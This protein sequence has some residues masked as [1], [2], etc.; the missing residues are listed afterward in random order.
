MNKHLLLQLATF[1]S[2][3]S[4]IILTAAP[5]QA[6]SMGYSTARYEGK[7]SGC[8][9]G[10]FLDPRNGGECWSC[11]NDYNRTLYAVTDDKACAKP[12]Y[13]KLK[14]AHKVRKNSRIGQG[15]GRGDFWDMK[16]GDGLLGACY[17]CSGWD[18]TAYAVDSKRACS[19][20]YPEKFAKA[21]KHGRFGCGQGQ[22]FDPR[23]YGE[24]WSCPDAYKFRTINP[25]TSRMACS[26][27]MFGIFAID[28]SEACKQVIHTLSEAANDSQ[29]VMATLDAAIAPIKEP[30]E[31]AVNELT[32]KIKAPDELT[33]LSERF[34]KMVPPQI[35]TAMDATQAA[36]QNAAKLQ[37]VILNQDLMCAAD[38][39]KI[40]RQLNA[41]GLRPDIQLPQ[42]WYWAYSLGINAPPSE[43]GTWNLTAVLVT[44]FNGSGGV[45]LVPGDS[46]TTDTGNALSLTAGIMAFPWARSI[47]VFSYSPDLTDPASFIPDNQL[48]ISGDFGEIQKK[49]FG[50]TLP[51][52]AD[53]AWTVGS[54]EA[55]G[56]GLSKGIG[57]EESR[58]PVDATI[59]VSTSFKVITW[60]R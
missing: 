30:M 44:N 42:P 45:F 59:G 36:M 31:R 7:T 55:W 4:I 3:L 46:L 33:E 24:C 11:P 13:E 50:K 47:E 58:H 27:Q 53:I 28:G 41:L 34:Q 25:V 51:D 22:F 12:A 49:L 17:T 37:Q 29:K 14:K 21:E 35:G 20:R 54:D 60:G 40:E 5:V 6:A 2:S 18:R 8:G 52:S 32:D 15:C 23:N 43:S 26:N 10:T 1:L 9:A 48:S 57:G 56:F 38:P 19:K 16:G 39:A